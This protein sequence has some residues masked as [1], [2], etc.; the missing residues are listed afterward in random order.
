[1]VIGEKD[2]TFGNNADFHRYLQSLGIAHGWTVIPGV[3]HDPDLVFTSLGDD[4]WPFYREAFTE[5][6]LGTRKGGS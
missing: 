5:P 4:N 3:G 6:A 2:E 1:M